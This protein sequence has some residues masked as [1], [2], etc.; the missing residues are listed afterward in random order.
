V[1]MRRTGPGLTAGAVSFPR[2]HVVRYHVGSFRPGRDMKTKDLR[3]GEVYAVVPYATIPQHATV[4]FYG[5]KRARLVE[6]YAE[7]KAR[8]WNKEK[9]VARVALDDGTE[10]DLSARRILGTWAEREEGLELERQNSVR[11]ARERAER[12]AVNGRVIEDLNARMVNAGLVLEDGRPVVTFTLDQR[13]NLVER[14]TLSRDNTLRSLIEKI[15][16]EVHA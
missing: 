7:P 15:T 11:W 1:L 13:G 5:A 2:A 4:T 6:A 16:S 10:R 12:M 3:V 14:L 8:E 9:A